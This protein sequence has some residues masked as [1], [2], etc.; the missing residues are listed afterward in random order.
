MC[1]IYIG[2]VPMA[3]RW[4]LA[5]YN[6]YHCADFERFLY[7]HLVQF[8]S[9]VRLSMYHFDCVIQALFVIERYKS[10][11]VA[12]YVDAFRILL[13]FYARCTFLL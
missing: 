4:N 13:S 9:Y 8:K 10:R 12:P 5:W 7:V 1:F 3:N 2:N 11:Y 6:V